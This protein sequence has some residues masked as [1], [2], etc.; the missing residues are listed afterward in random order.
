M[1]IVYFLQSAYHI[2]LLV[3]YIR[4]MSFL[5]LE[6]VFARQ[7]HREAITNEEV[8]Q[9]QKSLNILNEQH[10]Q[11]EEAWKSLRWIPDVI[12]NVSFKVLLS[13]LFFIK[14]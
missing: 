13:Y 14:K 1:L 10:Q 5:D 11:L 9:A 4:A 6:L 8:S 12:N 2:E 3:S 7:V